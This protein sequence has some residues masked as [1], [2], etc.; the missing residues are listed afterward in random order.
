[1]TAIS[2]GSILVIAVSVLLF[3]ATPVFWVACLL[4][5]VVG[6]GIII[7]NVTNQTLIQ[8]ATDPAFRGRVLS[9][10]G[11]FA[12]G[13]PS[14]GALFIGILAEHMGLRIPV[15]GGALLCLLLW[16]WAWQKRKSLAA[17]MEADPAG[18]N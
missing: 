9:I 16:L 15:A 17:S 11:M 7:Q 5:G 12:Q 1:M 2:I 3:V 8:S 6:I 4:S 10:Y 14:L 13:V 18:K